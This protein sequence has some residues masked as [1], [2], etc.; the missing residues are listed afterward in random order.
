[1]TTVGFGDIVPQTTLG[2]MLAA[3]VMIIGYGIIAVPT[4][5]VTI[6]L[7]RAARSASEARCPGCAL[8]RHDADATFCKHCGT[9]IGAVA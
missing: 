9:R 4:G 2:R 1:M 3:L 5:I 7:D 6:E 8:T